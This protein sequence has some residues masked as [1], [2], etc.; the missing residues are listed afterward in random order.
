[1]Y[2]DIT[3]SKLCDYCGSKFFRDKRNTWTHWQNAKFCSRACSSH[4]GADQRKAKTPTLIHAFWKKV[5]KGN[6]G[7]CWDWSGNKDKDGYPLVSF[8]GKMFRANRIAILTKGEELMDGYHACHSCGNKSCCNPDH[9]YLG[10]PMQNNADKKH[11]GTYRCGEKI[12]CAKLTENDVLQI[13]KIVGTDVN[14]AKMFG[15]SPS[16]ICQIRNRK[17]WRHLP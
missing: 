8:R 5:I 10:T 17:T 3:N 9:I 12:H 11:H 2:K 4:H 15:V 14:I 16:N 1:M 13:R 6:D 7:E